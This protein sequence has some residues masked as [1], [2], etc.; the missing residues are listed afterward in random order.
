MLMQFL[1]STIKPLSGR[2]LK[3]WKSILDRWGIK[4]HFRS[5]CIFKAKI[6]K[7]SILNSSAN[8]A[9]WQ[10][11]IKK[12]NLH[13]E[14]IPLKKSPTSK[15][16]K[17]THELEK[18][19]DTDL[20][21]RRHKDGKEEKKARGDYLI[22][23]L[24]Y[25]GE[26]KRELLYCLMGI[27]ILGAFGYLSSILTH[28]SHLEHEINILTSTLLSLQTQNQTQMQTQMHMQNTSTYIPSYSNS[29]GTLNFT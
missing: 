21:W 1:V 7:N 11:E 29:S 10:A 9:I 20:L 18:A 22:T 8:F 26:Y 23:I 25:V 17:L 13:L 28:I 24:F 27:L 3:K 19:C 4:I 12:R 2:I 16:S 5:S 6:M 14:K 15:T